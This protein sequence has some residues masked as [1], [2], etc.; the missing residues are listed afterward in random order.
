LNTPPAVMI[1][2][3]MAMPLIASPSISFARLFLFLL[4]MPKY[5]ECAITEISN[6]ITELPINL[7]ASLKTLPVNNYQQAQKV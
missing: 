3:I 7:I 4:V 1:R 6:A 5:R 2:S